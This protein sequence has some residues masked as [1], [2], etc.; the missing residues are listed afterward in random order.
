MLLC[1]LAGCLGAIAARAL[2][3]RALLWHLR[4]GV[5]A[6]NRGDHRPILASFAGDA[7]LRFNTGPHRWAGEHRGKDAIERFL[8][9]FVAAGLKGE[10]RALWIAG[11][12]WA[13]RLCARFDDR[14]TGP[15]GEMIYENRTCLVARTRWG[16]IVEQED[17]YVD[18]SRIVELDQALERMGIG[19]GRA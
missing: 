15:D 7:V 9:S 8:R 14:A 2:L 3:V 18:T 11:P 4:S 19:S 13:L 10:I 1:F 12:P 6:L 5:A 16:K 17:F